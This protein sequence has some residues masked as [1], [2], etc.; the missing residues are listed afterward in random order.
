MVNS[1]AP[2]GREDERPW[3][4][5]CAKASKSLC[6]RSPFPLMSWGLYSFLLKDIN[7]CETEANECDENANCSNTEGNYTCRCKTGF[8]GDGS[9]CQGTTEQNTVHFHFCCLFFRLFA[10]CEFMLITSI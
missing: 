8:E 4:R 3:E 10:F 7:E 6:M 2:R 9:L 5:G 1:H